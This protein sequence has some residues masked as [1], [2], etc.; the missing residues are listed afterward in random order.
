LSLAR[1][2]FALAFSLLLVA[3][4]RPSAPG[5]ASPS[6]SSIAGELVPSQPMSVVFHLPG[7]PSGLHAPF[8]FMTQEEALVA[9]DISV[10]IATPTV[11]VDPFGGA[12]DPGTVDLYVASPAAALSS[13]EAGSDLVLIAGLAQQSDWRLVTTA[14]SG[15]SEITG[16]AGQSIFVHGLP[17]DAATALAALSAAG[18]DP[19]SLSLTYATDLSS[20]FDPIPILDGT[21][22]AA[23]VS[24]IDGWPRLVQGPDL[25]TGAS[26]G[27]EGLVE[28]SITPTTFDTGLAIWAHASALTSDNAKIAAA[29][30]LV[31]LAEGLAFCRDF[32]EDC[33]ALFLGIGTS[34]QD[35]ETLVWSVNALNN[36]LWPAANGV[37]WIDIDG[38]TNAVATAVSAG[39]LTNQFKNEY[40]DGSVLALAELHWPADLDRKGE[41]WSVLTLEIPLY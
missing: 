14:N 24:S 1:R 15:I 35:Q 6:A 13:R 2:S 28:F 29:A 38:I 34:D 31:A 23:I 40:V 30:S 19:A 7:A 12:E 10:S 22:A 17:G 3:A 8:A 26:V 9:A 37:L 36:Q 11:G 32:I 27:V 21:Y 4:C 41:S 5:E 39:V 16:L 18:V 20:S 33:A 25:V